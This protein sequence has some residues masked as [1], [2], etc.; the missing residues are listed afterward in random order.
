MA[1]L[2][3]TLFH[4]G[5]HRPL[6]STTPLQL[7]D[8]TFYSLI[9]QPNESFPLL[10]KRSLMT[11]GLFAQIPAFAIHLRNYFDEQQSII[12]QCN[13]FRSRYGTNN[14]VFVHVRLGDIA[15][16]PVCLKLDYY[17]TALLS[18]PSFEQAYISSDSIDHPICKQLIKKYN[19]HIVTKN[20]VDTIKFASTCKHVVL[21][22]G[23][24]SWLIGALAFDSNVYYPQHP[25]Y[26]WWHGN[27]FVFDD[28]HVL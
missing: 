27:I 5:V 4:Q 10:E 28:W 25:R 14:D 12:R 16:L 26:K 22:T 23:T 20:E 7:N 15:N 11:T 2:G 8:R 24:F 17:D 19:M 13:Q 1:M 6:V 21:S 9:T 18:I 3:L